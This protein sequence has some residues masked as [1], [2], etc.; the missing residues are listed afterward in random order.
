MFAPGVFGAGIVGVNTFANFENRAV[1]ITLPGKASPVSGSRIGRGERGEVSRQKRLARHAPEERLSLVRSQP[2]VGAKHKNPVVDDR[3][4][5][6]AAK[7]IALILGLGRRKVILRVETVAAVELV[8]RT[9]QLVRAGLGHDGHDC[10]SLA[11]LGGERVSKQADFLHRIDRWVQRQVVETQRPH[12]HAVDRVVGGAVAPA[13]DGDELVPAAE[14]CIAREVSRRHTGRERG[15]RQH[16]AAVQRQ[17]HDLLLVDDLSNGC[18]LRLQQRRIAGDGHGFAHGRDAERD[19][20]PRRLTLTQHEIRQLSGPET[21]QLD[22]D[23]IGGRRERRNGESSFAVSDGDAL[24]VGAH[25]RD[26]DCSARDGRLRRVRHLPSQT[27]GRRL[28]SRGHSRRQQQRA[29]TMLAS[30]RVIGD[31]PRMR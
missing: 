7:R 6:G 4:S 9:V 26:R 24:G 2:L 22:L 3:T 31:S 1:G 30:L 11:V 27:G 8:G 15:E 14:L 19:R 18:V 28:L 20:R 13:L 5:A 16:G 25:V 23:V 10:L 12:V 29:N 21:L 17:V